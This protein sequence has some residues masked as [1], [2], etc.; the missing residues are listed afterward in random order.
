MRRVL[1][2]LVIASAARLSAQTPAQWQDIV[3]NLRNPNVAIR[4][5]A[6]E[7]LAAANYAAAAEPVSALLVD[8]DDKVQQAAL[9]AELTFFV[10]DRVSPKRGFL[11]DGKSRAQQAFEAGP[12]VRSSYHAGR[13]T[14]GANGEL[15]EDP[16]DYSKDPIFTGD[17]AP[18]VAGYPATPLVQ[19]KGRTQTE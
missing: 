1:L 6:V 17:W 8:A 7:R 11:G 2:C 15:S 13:H 5:D 16:N 9:D 14:Q 3:R 4:L 18:T 10:A 12:L 19:L